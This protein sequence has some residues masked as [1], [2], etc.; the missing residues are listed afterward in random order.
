[1]SAPIERAR[2]ADAGRAYRYSVSRLH[3]PLS[4]EEQRRLKL[5]ERPSRT[6]LAVH[7]AT[8]G[9]LLSSWS[10]TEA[11]IAFPLHRI[12]DVL[13][14]E[15]F[16]DSEGDG[17]ARVGGRGRQARYR[18]HEGLREL[19]KRGALA[20]KELRRN[21]VLAVTLHLP[22]PPDHWDDPTYRQ[23]QRDSVTESVTGVTESVTGVTESVTGVTESVTSVTGSLMTDE[24]NEKNNEQTDEPGSVALAGT[25]VRPSAMEA[26]EQS[27]DNRIAIASGVALNVERSAAKG[28]NGSR[29]TRI[30]RGHVEALARA[31]PE[32]VARSHP[33]DRQHLAATMLGH[34]GEQHRGTLDKLRRYLA[35]GAE[36]DV[37][38]HLNAA[39]ARWNGEARSLAGFV[40]TWL[41]DLPPEPR[42]RAEEYR[43]GFPLRDAMMACGLAGDRGTLRASS[44]ALAAETVLDAGHDPERDTD[45]FAATLAATVLQLV[46]EDYVLETG[47]PCTAELRRLA[48]DAVPVP[49]VLPEGGVDDAPE[50]GVAAL[51]SL[52]MGYPDARLGKASPDREAA[53]SNGGWR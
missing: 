44:F 26:E 20:V 48:A 9:A 50:R 6:A 7:T 17:A 38:K 19:E 22:M 33:H 40:L 45:G 53:S 30:E 1:L 8:A 41:G 43:Y 49:F 24:K 51:R 13:A 34:G 36:A 25:N 35:A 28:E 3:R 27:T 37:A 4:D 5:P 21:G 2:Y 10:R 11:E 14:I 15:P 23:A 16:A 39:A 46:E 42:Y 12:A 47:E 29:V 32:R 18:L 31:I 52:G